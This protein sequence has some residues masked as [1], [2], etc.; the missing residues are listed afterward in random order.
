[1]KVK[2]PEA[3]PRNPLTIPD[4]I[5]KVVKQNI[6]FVHDLILKVKSNISTD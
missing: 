3:A 1:M 2:L 5:A 6:T 4:I